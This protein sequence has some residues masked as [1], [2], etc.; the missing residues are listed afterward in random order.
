MY[1][2]VDQRSQY[3]YR[4]EASKNS[5]V[6]GGDGGNHSPERLRFG[7][8]HMHGSVCAL[9][10]RGSHLAHLRWEGPVAAYHALH[11]MH[12]SP[13]DQVFTF[14]PLQTQPKVA[15]AHACDYTQPPKPVHHIE[16]L[17]SLT[18]TRR[19]NPWGCGSL[20]RRGRSS[21]YTRPRFGPSRYHRGLSTTA[22]TKWPHS[23]PLKVNIGRSHRFHLRNT[24]VSQPYIMLERIDAR[25][26]IDRR[27]CV[28]FQ[29]LSRKE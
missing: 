23:R 8:A 13:Q 9:W 3:S 20:W 25:S 4:E 26:L 17:Q 6:I 22:A 24:P 19:G 29:E 10:G 7:R 5:L 16:G 1:A 27:P 28:S 21:L 12:M 18:T 15:R 2:D 11:S 14:Y